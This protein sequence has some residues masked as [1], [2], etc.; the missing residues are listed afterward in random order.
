MVSV[1]CM[2][3]FPGVGTVLG[4]HWVLIKYILKVKGRD[5]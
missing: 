5:D 3:L 1:S 4:T 2:A